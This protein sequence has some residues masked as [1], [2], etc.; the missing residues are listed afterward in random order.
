MWSESLHS[1]V[2]LKSLSQ[3]KKERPLTTQV[4]DRGRCRWNLNVATSLV[5]LSTKRT[6]GQISTAASSPCENYPMILGFFSSIEADRSY[7][8]PWVLPKCKRTFQGTEC[9]CVCPCHKCRAE[10]TS[11]LVPQKSSASWR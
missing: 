9:R 2:E 4:T 10:Q 5:K 7:A 3:R 8:A 6:V 1:T 11:Q